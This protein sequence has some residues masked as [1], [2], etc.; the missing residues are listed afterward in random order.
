[1]R[2]PKSPEPITLRQVEPEIQKG[3]FTT[4]VQPEAFGGVTT[5]NVEK[6]GQTAD[7]GLKVQ[8]QA[9]NYLVNK[10]MADWSDKVSGVRAQMTNAKGE[11][12]QQ[13]TPDIQDGAY[14]KTITPIRQQVLDVAKDNPR[15]QNILKTRLEKAESLLKSDINTNVVKQTYLTNV[16]KYDGRIDDIQKNIPTYLSPKSIAGHRE[17]L[18]ELVKQRL[19]VV[20][21]SATTDDQ[22]DKFLQMYDSQVIKNFAAKGDI[23]GA[24]NYAK[25][26]Q[27]DGGVIN[28]QTQKQIYEAGT[29]QDA[30]SWYKTQSAAYKTSDGKPDITRI[31]QN[32]PKGLTQ[33]QQDIYTKTIMPKYNIDNKQVNSN[34]S[35]LMNQFK[36]VL[37]KT[38]DSS[39]IL[40]EAKRLS[41]DGASYDAMLKLASN[42]KHGNLIINMGGGK[43]N[44]LQNI[45]HNI[46]QG[47][48]EG[49]VDQPKLLSLFNAGVL[50]NNSFENGQK[51]LDA[52]NKS[53]VNSS[54]ANF[55]RS[56]NREIKDAYAGD[57]DKATEFSREWYKHL[58]DNPDAS[59]SDLRKYVEENLKPAPKDPVKFWNMLQ[60]EDS[61]DQPG[62]AE[63][64]LKATVGA[65]TLSGIQGYL[66]SSNPSNFMP[67]EQ[68]HDYMRQLGATMDDMAVGQPI[69]NAIQSVLDWNKI[70]PDQPHSLKPELILKIAH[71]YPGGMAF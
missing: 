21:K 30:E 62:P 5:S 6:I 68:L 57:P 64:T 37:S 54:K 71:E 66:R 13:F 65:S 26:I 16:A 33:D 63:Q 46:Y 10:G 70:H 20:G 59:T 28:S 15:A 18:V 17:D 61:S 53:G 36:G 19:A 52:S 14:S 44:E 51:L 45:H 11:N 49:T 29:R 41:W 56:V 27:D 39:T 7:L 22:V 47:I 3:D 58:A 60:Q 31:L 4:R 43:A 40:K 67:V 34:H 50:D 8:E 24:R 32:M 42:P 55:S 2:T 1:M 25:S 23:R 9:D 12:A 35:D 38:P 48:M 69:N